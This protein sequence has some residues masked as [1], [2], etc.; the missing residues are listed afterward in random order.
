[1]NELLKGRGLFIYSDPGGAK[2]VLSLVN[3]LKNL[4]AYQIISDREYFFAKIF[5][6]TVSPFNDN[7]EEIIRNF[8]PDFIFT[9]TSYTS[10]IELRFLK[11]AHKMKIP[12]ISFVD[13]LTSIKERFR[14]NEEFVFPNKIW[15]IDEEAK[16]IALREEIAAD[17]IIVNENPYHT[18]LKNWKPKISRK[19]FFASVHVSENKKIIVFAPDPLTSVGG[20]DKFGFDEISVLSEILA[21]LEQIDQNKKYQLVIQLHPNQQTEKITELIQIRN[22]PFVTLVTS[23]I[24]TNE[25]L[26]YSSS[27]IGFFSNILLEAKVFEKK[28]LRLLLHSKINDPFE[29]LAV[30]DVIKTP[31]KLKTALTSLIKN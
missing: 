27:V 2:P 5:E 25:L 26:F 24:E 22:L 29:Y 3:S 12:S 23:Q 15:L 31:E 18:Y 16:K 9:G 28:I 7:E 1:M 14:L 11:K 20:K 10:K 8:H 17:K 13:H 30:G 4:S 21:C 19:D 6:V